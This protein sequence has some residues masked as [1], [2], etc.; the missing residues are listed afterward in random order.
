MAKKNQK[1][2]S[3]KIA[4][5]VKEGKPVKQAAGEA[6]GMARAGK[7]TKEGGYKKSK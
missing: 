2:I 7:L 1:A 4:H 3:K 5:L 6:Y